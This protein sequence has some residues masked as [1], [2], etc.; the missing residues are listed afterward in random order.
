MGAVF[1]GIFHRGWRVRAVGTIGRRPEGLH[2]RLRLDRWLYL[3]VPDTVQLI[4][5]SKG[6]YDESG[7]TCVRWKFF[8]DPSVKTGQ[9]VYLNR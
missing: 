4:W 9:V 2:Q 7:S 3:I 5:S 1:G 8:C 6:E